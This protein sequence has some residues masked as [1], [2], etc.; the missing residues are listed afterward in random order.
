M[1]LAAAPPT[2]SVRRA[3]L[4]LA[5]LLGV[6]SAAAWWA[7]GQG[8]L[9]AEGHLALRAWLAPFGWAAPL[10]FVAFK[11]GGIAVGLPTSP[12]TLAG[13]ALFG[14]PGGLLLNVG[15][16][17]LGAV[18]PFAYARWWGREAVAQRLGGRLAEWDAHVG[19]R[20][21]W[22][23]LFVRLV[24]VVPF[25]FINFAAGLSKVRFRDFLAATLIGIVPGAGAITYLGA[26]AA[27]GS[28]KGVAMALGCLGALALL[29]MLWRP[30]AK[31][32]A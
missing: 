19:E 23:I 27:D 11:V 29:P 6:A 31:P 9:G 8:L 24:P 7:R 25:T 4:G 32:Q 12:L 16:G 5:L 10:A 22:A 13:G 3:A 18:F 14:F 26:S 30:R 2:R 21:F 1:S 17:T 20:G 28:V 15:G